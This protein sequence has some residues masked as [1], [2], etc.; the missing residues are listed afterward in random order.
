MGG[1]LRRKRFP[2]R[3]WGTKKDALNVSHRALTKGLH[4]CRVIVFQM[5][6]EVATQ[7]L[8]EN[9]QQMLQLCWQTL[10]LWGSQ[11]IFFKHPSIKLRLRKARPLRN[12]PLPKVQALS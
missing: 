8:R 4:K 7:M 1:I 12:I 3:Q 2:R 11:R 10:E 6:Q 9:R 5:Q